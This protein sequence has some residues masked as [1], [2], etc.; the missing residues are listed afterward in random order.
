MTGTAQQFIRS[1]SLFLP[2]DSKNPTIGQKVNATI[3]LDDGADISLANINQLSVKLN[4]ASGFLKVI[5]IEIRLGNLVSSS[6][7]L[8]NLTID[9]MKGEIK[10][11]IMAKSTRD[12]LIG[13]GD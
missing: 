2:A 10:F 8:E 13:A 4:Y 3:R 6:F 1:T 9:D 12:I 11:N 5:P 7:N